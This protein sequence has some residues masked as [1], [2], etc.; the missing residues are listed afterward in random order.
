MG[1]KL[2]IRR[3]TDAMPIIT[4]LKEVAA[5]LKANEI[6][7]W[8]YLLEGGEDEE[9]RQSVLAGDTYA[10]YLDNAMVANFTLSSKQ[11]EWDQ[12]IW[13]IED[14]TDVFYLHRLAVAPSM[15]RKGLGQEI[16]Q[17]ILDNHDQPIRLDCVSGHPKLA[18]FYAE[19]GFTLVGQSADG[20]YKFEK[21]G[22]VS[23][24]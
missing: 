2:D 3:A 13:G 12:Y 7:Q 19:N 5:W 11:S 1:Q 9:I 8:R 4:L 21:E 20:H 14:Q 15:M 22:K 23:T 6:D 24:R 16:L 18:N 10:V 17:W